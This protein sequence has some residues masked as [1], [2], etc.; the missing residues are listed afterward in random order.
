MDINKWPK[1]RQENASLNCQQ[2]SN[3]KYATVQHLA[4]TKIC[5]GGHNG[6]FQQKLLKNFMKTSPQS[7]RQKQKTLFNSFD[8]IMKFST[9]IPQS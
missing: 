2:T 6:K 9:I 4:L 5:D 1:K 3:R 8:K 7:F